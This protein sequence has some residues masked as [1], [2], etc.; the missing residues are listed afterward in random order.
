MERPGDRIV[1]TQ[2]EDSDPLPLGRGRLTARGIPPERPAA[3][4][5]GPV[6]PTP[7]TQIGVRAAR[8]SEPEHVMVEL[9]AAGAARFRALTRGLVQEAALRNV[10]D[11]VFAVVLDGAEITRAT[12]SAADYPHGIEGGN[13]VDLLLTAGSSPRVVAALVNTPLPDLDVRP[14]RGWTSYTPAP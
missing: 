8:A 2:P 13:G 7:I 5:S 4:G 12:V 9:T 3:P 6:A 11:A 1:V 14:E 10:P